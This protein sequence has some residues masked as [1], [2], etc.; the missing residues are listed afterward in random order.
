MEVYEAMKVYVQEALAQVFLHASTSLASS[1]FFF[2]KKKDGGLRLCIDYQTLNKATVKFSYPL[3]LISTVIEQMHGAQ[4]FTKLDLRNAYNLVRTRHYKYRVMPYGMTNAPSVFKSF[5]NKVF[6]D[7]LGR[8][9]VV[10]VTN[11]L[12]YSTTHMSYN[13]S[14]MSG[15]F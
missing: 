11:I 10:Y 12:V 2:V 7:M 13:M 5:I 14:F 3:P 9:V 1:S 15:P 6:R 4:Y 8:C